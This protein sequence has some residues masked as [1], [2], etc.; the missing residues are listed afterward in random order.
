MLVLSRKREESVVIGPN[1]EVRVLEIMGNRVRLGVVAPPEVA[2]HRK[3]VWVRL[4]QQEGKNDSS[5]ST[6]G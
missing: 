3:E 4:H 1:I 5:Q 6:A 2:V